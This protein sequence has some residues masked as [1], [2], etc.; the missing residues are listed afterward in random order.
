MKRELLYIFSL[1]YYNDKYKI[2]KSF[3]KGLITYNLGE[4][5]FKDLYLY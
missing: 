3:L 1:L 4:R 2:S 5:A